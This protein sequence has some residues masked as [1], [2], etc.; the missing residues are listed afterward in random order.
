M[1][2]DLSALDGL[3]SEEEQFKPASVA[4]MAPLSQFEE[5]PENPRFEFD[6]PEFADFAEDIRTRGILQPLVVRQMESGKLRIRFGARRYR[7]A[8]LI[9]LAEVPY[10]IT[11]DARQFDDYSQVSENQRR[12]NLTPLELARFIAKRIEAKDK[13]TKIAEHLRIDASAITHLLAL[14]DPPAFLMELYQSGKC[15]SPSYLYEL[16]KLHDKNSEIVERRCAEADEITRR[17]IS[18]IDAEINPPA[19]APSSIASVKDVLGNPNAGGGGQPGGNSGSKEGEIKDA[20]TS[21]EAQQIPP[22]NPAIEKDKDSK[23]SDPNKIKKPLLL[24]TYEGR[25]VMVLLNQRP[26]A[27][28]LVFVRYEDGSGDEAVQIGAVTLTMLSES[29]A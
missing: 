10:V 5:D 26:T 4:P 11:E 20:G 17:L 18:A 2:L 22:H 23:P 6:D 14:V 3:G 27:P 7:A 16:R 8:R 9:G 24:G 21:G 13:K 28:G 29:T 15:R 1:A 19:I 25:D 12:K